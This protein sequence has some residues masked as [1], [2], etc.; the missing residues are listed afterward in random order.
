M[1]FQVKFPF[2]PAVS[3]QWLSP[4]STGTGIYTVGVELWRQQLVKLNERER[5]RPFCA[6]FPH[7]SVAGALQTRQ[8]RYSAEG[9]VLGM[10]PMRKPG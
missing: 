5:E 2:A 9:G 10:A 4:A 7:F 1:H 3:R 6:Q 8:P